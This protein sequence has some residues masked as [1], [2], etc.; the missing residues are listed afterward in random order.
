VGRASLHGGRGIYLGTGAATSAHAVYALKIVI[1]LEGTLRYSR[2]DG[3]RVAMK[4]LVAAPGVVHAIDCGG[5]P[6]ALLY[7]LPESPRYVAMV[8]DLVAQAPMPLPEDLVERFRG[9]LLR[10]FETDSAP[11]VIGGL[12]DE[13]AHAALPDGARSSVDRRVARAMA[14]VSEL[15][16][17]TTLGIVAERVRISPTWLTHLFQAEVGLSFKHY[18]LT[19]RLRRAIEGFSSSSSLTA[20]AHDVGFSD[21]AHLSRTS[22]RML[23]VSPS[24]IVLD[25]GGAE[26]AA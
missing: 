1:P 23:G 18:V 24:D 21:L 20:L 14:L 4:S 6:V 12:A 10:A 26:R 7:V 5:A 25:A 16:A 15:E 2:A 11:S 22:R 13:L 3:T 9:P 8:R 19:A 17:A